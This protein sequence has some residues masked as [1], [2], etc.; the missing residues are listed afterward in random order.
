MIRRFLAWLD[1]V[2]PFGGPDAVLA[3]LACQTAE[4]VDSTP[5]FTCNCAELYGRAELA[6][7]EGIARHFRLAGPRYV[8]QWG[9]A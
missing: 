5:S 6:W 3:D 9:N 2:L 4:P 7:N 1:D 8:N